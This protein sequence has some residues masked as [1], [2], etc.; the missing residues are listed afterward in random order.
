[1]PHA[2]GCAH[3]C[4]R[5]PSTCAAAGRRAGAERRGLAG[6]GRVGGRASAPAAGPADRGREDWAAGRDHAPHRR[7]PAPGHPRLPGVEWCAAAPCAPPPPQCSERRPHG[8]EGAAPWPPRW[9]FTIAHWCTKKATVGQ[10]PS[11]TRGAAP[12]VQPCL[13]RL[14]GGAGTAPLGASRPGDPVHGAAS[15]PP[16]AQAGQGRS[17]GDPGDPGD[18]GAAGAECLHGVV[19][20]DPLGLGTPEDSARGTTSFPMNWARRPRSTR[21]SCAASRRPS[22]TR[23]APRPTSTARPPAPCGA[24]T[25]RGAGRGA[26]AGTSSLGRRMRARP[27]MHVCARRSRSVTSASSD[28]QRPRQSAAAPCCG[29]GRTEISSRKT[30]RSER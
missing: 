11:S 13:Q 4:C 17:P 6:H 25:G 20:T 14:H 2:R 12:V 27:A 21:R 16:P 10:R 28:A 7:R 1:M 22:A 3:R 5:L 8:Q 26:L 15:A 29:Q 24:R 30:G 9:T 19:D 23:R 18:P